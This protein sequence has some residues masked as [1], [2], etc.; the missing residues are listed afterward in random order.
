M[1]PRTRLIPLAG[2]LALLAA[3]GAPPQPKPTSPPVSAPSPAVPPV[4]SAPA[5]PVGT[6]PTTPV[7]TGYP[8]ATTY[9][10]YTPPATTAP[11]EKPATPTPSH[12][13]KCSGEPTGTQILALIKGAT[14]IPATPLRVYEGPFCS[15]AWSFTT[16]EET[17]KDRDEVEPLM[18]VSTGKGRLLALVTA[19]SDVCIDRV[20]TEAPAGIRVL[21]CGF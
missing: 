7:P 15:G 10:A 14:G 2:A 16:V 9:P 4:A 3:C 20:Q 19:G 8:T 5:L 6:L 12:A 17:G 1:S 11:T 13:A 21:A 18:V